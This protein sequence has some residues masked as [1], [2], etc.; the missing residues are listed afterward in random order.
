MYT[1]KGNNHH[2][3]G[4]DMKAEVGMQVKAY[5]GRCIDRK[6]VV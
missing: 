1:T 6:S 2:E 5:T 3:G 4:T